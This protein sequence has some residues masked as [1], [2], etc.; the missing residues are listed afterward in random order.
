MPANSIAILPP[1]GYGSE[2]YSNAAICWLEWEA[3]ERSIT[4]RHARNSYEI[5]I[6]PYKCDGFAETTTE[7][8][9]FEYNGCVSG[10]KTIQY[11]LIIV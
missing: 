8:L 1:Q 9:I 2:K 3:K 7:K 4:I 6:G 5:K 10:C 11:R